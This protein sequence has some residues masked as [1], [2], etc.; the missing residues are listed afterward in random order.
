MWE[1]KSRFVI[2]YVIAA[3]A[4][5][6]VII[7]VRKIF[8]EYMLSVVIFAAVFLIVYFQLKKRQWSSEFLER[9]GGSFLSG[10]FL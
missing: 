8:W 9:F 4:G 3:L 6:F 5:I 2:S 10:G 7:C 1:R